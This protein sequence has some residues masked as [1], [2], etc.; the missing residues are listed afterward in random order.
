MPAVAQHHTK[1]L[2]VAAR[3][4]LLIV[5]GGV[6]RGSR[7][8]HALERL[9]GRRWWGV[10][11]ALALVAGPGVAAMSAESVRGGVVRVHGADRYETAARVTQAAFAAEADVVYLAGG[12]AWPDALA[13]GA[14]AAHQRAPVLLTPSGEL[15]AAALGEIQRLDPAAVVVVGGEAA[16]SAG[17]AEALRAASG[18]HVRRI[19]GANRYATA[20]A[21][22]VDSYASGAQTAVVASGEAFPDA[23]TGVPLAAALSA[24]LLLVEADAVPTETAEALERLAPGRVLV[25]GGEAAVHDEVL[26]ELRHT[27]AQ[28]ERI[29]GG[30]RF[31]TAMAIDAARPD[32][33][34][35]A[36][37]LLASGEAF[38]DALAA[39]PAA[40]VLGARLLLTHP[41]ALPET[42]RDALRRLSPPT[43]TIVGG[44]AAVGPRGIDVV[45]T[46]LGMTPPIDYAGTMHVPSPYTCGPVACPGSWTIWAIA[47][48]GTGH[49]RIIEPADERAD[50]FG[51][52]SP[53]GDALMFVR[54]DPRFNEG[55]QV[56]VANLDGDIVGPPR[57]I[58]DLPDYDH[59]PPPC[60]F[61]DIRWMADGRHLAVV[62]AR[63]PDCGFAYGYPRPLAVIDT[64]TRTT[65][66]SDADDACDAD[67]A[68]SRDNRIAFLRFDKAAATAQLIVATVTEGPVLDE[69]VV[70]TTAQTSTQL[71]SLSSPAWAPR[72]DAIA[73]GIHTDDAA[74]VAVATTGGTVRTVA[75][76][77]G[78]QIL[79]IA[80]SPDSTVLAVDVRATDGAAHLWLI[81]PSAHSPARLVYTNPGT[82]QRPAFTAPR[83]LD[84]GRL[85]VHTPNG[86]AIL[87]ADGTTTPYG[88][89]EWAQPRPAAWRGVSGAAP[90][91]HYRAPQS[92]GRYR[93]APILRHT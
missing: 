87:A 69:H 77:P 83:W 6:G 33:T 80:W 50:F 15:S 90:A 58:A 66:R 26:D 45:R 24:P 3:R 12:E 42:T 88:P 61:R 37:V 41:L 39:G 82:P 31:I 16:V 4:Q 85:L 27:G 32:V 60:D 51:G 53:T 44:T 86:G 21:V 35:G 36:S 11:A 13:A 93:R 17:V 47:A 7:R 9:R 54:V 8:L 25:L 59:E 75:S 76:P 2:A 70:Y 49:R 46:T 29:G 30:D 91:R 43:V 40:A 79:G 73:F 92:P 78:T 14:A 74:H 65:V 72:G 22:A 63:L 84:D 38:A 28:V 71:R 1:D 23:L 18:R 56:Y 64:T 89:P 67:L 62:C 57:L 10:A 48:D 5:T 52:W 55:G 20:A 34:A 19:A 68:V 81:D